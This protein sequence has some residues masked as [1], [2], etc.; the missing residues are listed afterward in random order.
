VKL[1]NKI[2]SKNNVFTVIINILNMCERTLNCN[3][4]GIEEK[5]LNYEST[6]FIPC[7]LSLTQIKNFLK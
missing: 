6:P 3:H 4:F 1:L 2:T 7:G 5:V